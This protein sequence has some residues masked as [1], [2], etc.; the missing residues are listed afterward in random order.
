M[1][2]KK[3]QVGVY[4]CPKCA[5]FDWKSVSN[6]ADYFQCKRCKKYFTKHKKIMLPKPM[7]V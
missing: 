3:K 2:E 5:S 7:G 1:E 6:I 4:I